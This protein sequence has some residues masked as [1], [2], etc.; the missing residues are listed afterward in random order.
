MNSKQRKT[1]VAIF[2]DPVSSK[3]AWAEVESLL[4]AIGC[5]V[6]EGSGSRV[7]FN[8][9]GEVL[10]AHRPHPRKE[11]KPYQVREIR[12]FLTDIGVVP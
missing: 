1:L 9:D 2:A 3:I 5:K 11:C 12:G 6:I 10:M 7:K 8:K 4:V